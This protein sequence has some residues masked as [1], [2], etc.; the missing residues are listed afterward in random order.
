MQN[1]E[2]LMHCL[3]TAS[4]TCHHQVNINLVLACELFCLNKQDYS[5]NKGVSGLVY[6]C[7][8]YFY[9]KEKYLFV[10][11]RIVSGL[12]LRLS[13]KVHAQLR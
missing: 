9:N 8:F 11:C 3:S 12:E 4:I 5:V 10:S 7:H 2:D 13:K 6:F 1:L